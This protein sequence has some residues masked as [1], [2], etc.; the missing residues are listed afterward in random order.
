MG[1]EAVAFARANPG[2]GAH[3]YLRV[4]GL[5]SGPRISPASTGRTH[6]PPGNGR[7]C[8]GGRCTGACG[9]LPGSAARTRGGGRDPP[10]R[11]AKPSPRA[12]AVADH[13]LPCGLPCG[14]IPVPSP[15]VTAVCVFIRRRCRW[16]PWRRRS[17]CRRG[18]SSGSSS[19]SFSLQLVDDDRARGCSIW[20]MRL[21]LAAGPIRSPRPRG[22]VRWCSSSLRGWISRRRPGRCPVRRR[23]GCR[24]GWSWWPPQPPWGS[25][26]TPSPADTPLLIFIMCPGG[27]GLR[28]TGR[29]PVRILRG[30]AASP[31]GV[32]AAA[33]AGAHVRADVHRFSFP[34]RRGLS[35]V[36]ML[37]SGLHQP[38]GSMP[39]PAPGRT[40]V[41]TFIRAS[42]VS[43]CRRCAGPCPRG[44]WCGYASSSPVIGVMFSRWGRPSTPGPQ[45]TVV[46]VCIVV[47][48][49]S[50]CRRSARLLRRG[51]G[52]GC[53][54]SAPVQRSAAAVGVHHPPPR[55]RGPR[56]WSAWLLA[57]VGGQPSGSIADPVPA[58]T[59]VVARM[60]FTPGLEWMREGRRSAAVH[61]F[62]APAA[63]VVPALGPGV[64]EAGWRR[65]PAGRAVGD[66]RWSG[67]GRV[68]PGRARGRVGQGRDAAGG[69]SPGA[70]AVRSCTETRQISTGPCRHTDSCPRTCSRRFRGT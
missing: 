36:V 24:C 5:A 31:A 68:R 1:S 34:V 38:L 47:S 20:V 21:R 18:S 43:R 35:L 13:P 2:A 27:G 50:R 62:D 63:G 51:S 46:L 44:S 3:G 48:A 7:V 58:R 42:R 26:P 8:D 16:G 55:R 45:R 25:M 29:S 66:G 65:T 30:D 11:G 53:S 49:V 28:R 39:Q 54:R 10:P 4:R 69:G 60:V 57:R 17:R 61:S 70:A 40:W 37:I 14:S 67:R 41:E 32:D 33:A 19:S 59:V 56:W 12:A 6:A 22:A 52:S 64:S 15:A 9:R 23:R